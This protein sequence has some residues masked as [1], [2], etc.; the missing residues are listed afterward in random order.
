MWLRA[1]GGR[2]RERL[3]VW[4]EAEGEIECGRLREGLR[5]WRE[6]EVWEESRS[7]Y[8]EVLSV[9][10]LKMERLIKVFIFNNMH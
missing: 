7:C 1:C 9:L 6:A 5:V 10:R 8:E 3:R 4:R 2:L